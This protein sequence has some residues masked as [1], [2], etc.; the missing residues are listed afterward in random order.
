MHLLRFFGCKIKWQVCCALSRRRYVFQLQTAPSLRQRCSTRQ[1][2]SLPPTPASLKAQNVQI[3]A[4]TPPVQSD[5]QTPLSLTMSTVPFNPP[6]K[7]SASQVTNGYTN[8]C[9]RV[10]GLPPRC[11]AL[12]LLRVTHTVKL[13]P[14]RRSQTPPHASEARPLWSVCSSVCC[15]FELHHQ[16]HTQ[17]CPVACCCLNCRIPMHAHACTTHPRTPTHAQCSRLLSSLDGAA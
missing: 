11:S 13:R 1:R 6:W 16:E 2:G 8:S 5:S 17:V 4:E 7:L 10:P 9:E 12:K 3:F 15:G 14:S